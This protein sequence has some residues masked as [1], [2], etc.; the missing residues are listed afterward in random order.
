MSNY[1]NSNG[2]LI[3]SLRERAK[4]LNCLYAIEEV[5]TK[6]D[7]GLD[8]IFGSIVGVIP[9]GWQYPAYCQSKI[10]L[11]HLT[12]QSSNFKETPWVQSID[13]VVQ[14]KAIGQLSVYY[15]KEMPMADQGPFLKEESK[16]IQ[17][18]ADRLGHFIMYYRMKHLFQDKQDP[19]D[20]LADSRKQEWRVAL[21]LLRQTDR[22]LFL[23]ISH[24][25]LNFLCWSGIDEAKRLLQYYSPDQKDGEDEPPSDP[26]RPYQKKA[27]THS[28]DFLSDETF[29]IA[30]DHFNDEEILDIIQKW[31]QEDKVSFLVRTLNRNS[32]L[33][34]VADAIRR[35]YRISPH[36]TD[37]SSAS[38]RGVRVSLI[39]R[40]FSDELEFINIAK[41]YIDIGDFRDLLQNVIYTSES[42]GRLGGKSAG[43]FLASQII[44][45]VGG[46][47]E[48]LK[49]IKTPKTWY[50]AS[51]V[52]LYF[53]Q[54]NNLEGVVEQKYKEINQ[55]RLEYPNIIQTFKNAHFP[56][57]IIQ[58]LSTALDDF[59]NSP[60]IVRSS[61]L[62]EDRT[63][64]AFSGKY[65][66]LFLANQGSKQE[67]LE[68]LMDAIAEVYAS[69]FG[70]D[71]IEYRAERG[72]LDF[73][74]EMGIM[75]QEVVGTQIGHY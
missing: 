26:N 1:E 22:N 36:G 24:K 64:A 50:I 58:G 52:V 32:S 16:L 56:P 45:K 43:L 9:Q 11:E 2:K 44:K 6:S 68:A 10:I 73:H 38:H 39:R 23:S 46:D 65:K 8:H 47:L 21:D 19:I 37:V 18:I 14:D 25:M 70:P 40:F 15:T 29:K 33:A 42:H 53:M 28:S 67:Q 3:E 66:S 69:V 62:L 51:D 74:E 41:N 55:V 20:L 48:I 5:L 31:V 17:T 49:N 60:L 30:A 57:D 71:P 59:K 61:S 35:Y 63:G 34:E 12:Y 4:E 54:Y 27:L 7:A 72:L 13:I 75:I